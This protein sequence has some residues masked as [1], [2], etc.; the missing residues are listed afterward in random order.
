[1]VK[2]LKFK[3][4][5]KVILA[6]ALFAG[7]TA[8]AQRGNQHGQKRGLTEDL[9]VEQMATLKTKKLTLALDLTEKQQKQVYEVNLENAE[10][11]KAKIAE[12][13]AMKEAGEL[14]RPTGDERFAIENARLD[15]R[16]AHQEKMKQILNDEQYDQWK[17]MSHRK[18]MHSKRKMQK[19]FGRRG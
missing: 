5:K 6:M 12:R 3:N 14:K 1:M 17:K 8:M 7:L 15:R 19:D 13:K 4:M 18:H 16:I 10:A 2:S 9:T 11:R